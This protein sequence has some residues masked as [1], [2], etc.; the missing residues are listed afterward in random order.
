MY[1]YLKISYYERKEPVQNLCR[2]T[3]KTNDSIQGTI[4]VIFP[5]SAKFVNFWNYEPCIVIQL[6]WTEI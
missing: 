6:F 4:S 2:S 1:A 3:N 5:F